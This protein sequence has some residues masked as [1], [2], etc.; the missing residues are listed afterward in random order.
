MHGFDRRWGFGLAED[1]T[2]DYAL[3][4]RVDGTGLYYDFRSAEAGESLTANQTLY[5]E[6]R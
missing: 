1:R 6:Q 4:I 5:C 3:L 2:Y